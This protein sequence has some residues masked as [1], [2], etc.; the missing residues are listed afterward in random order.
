MVIESLSRFGTQTVITS[1]GQMK[2]SNDLLPPTQT[3]LTSLP[4]LLPL[5][6]EY[7][8]P[9]WISPKFLYSVQKGLP[10]ILEMTYF[11]PLGNIGTIGEHLAMPSTVLHTHRPTSLGTY[12]PN[13]RAQSHGKTLVMTISAI[14]SGHPSKGRLWRS[15]TTHSRG[16]RTGGTLCLGHPSREL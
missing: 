2:S 8:D 10:D 4:P 3:L 1:H 15:S 9:H 16:C 13:H 14:P 5:T 12:L 6:S 7:S 11:L